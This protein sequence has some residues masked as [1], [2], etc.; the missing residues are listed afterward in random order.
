MNRSLLIGIIA[1]IALFSG[2]AIYFYLNNIKIKNRPAIEAVPG[3]AFIILQSKDINKSWSLLGKSSLWADLKANP[4]VSKLNKQ[5]EE[6]FN[7]INGD[8]EFKE[9]F[10]ENTTAFSLHNNSNNL[11]L[12][13]IV[14]TGKPIELSD[15]T[16]Y[17]SKKINAKAI[18]RSFD[19]TPIYDFTDAQGN[20]LFTISYRD[21]LLL[22][23][24][25]A[26][27]VEESI[28]KLKYNLPNPTKGLTQAYLMAETSA[29]LN[30][31]INYQ[32]IHLLGNLFTKSEYYNI[33]SY[34]K[35]FA[36]W[37]M[38]DVELNDDMYKLSGVTFTDDSVFQFLDLFK[39]QT[40]KQLQ[41]HKYMPKNTAMAFQMGFSDYMKF[42]SELNEYLQVNKKGDLYVGFSDSIENRYNIDITQNILNYIDGEAS[43]V[44]T[45]PAGSDF[46]NNLNAF[47]RFKDPAG[48][49]TALKG[50]IQAMNR[51]GEIDSVTY[52]HQGL[53]I[54]RIKLGNFLKLYYGEIM[55]H[56]YSPYYV[57]LDDIFVFANDVNT[58]KHI[59]D[60]YKSGNTL[61]NDEKFKTYQEDLAVNNNVSIFISPTRNFLL[62]TNFVNDSF[63]STLN[64]FQYDFKKFEFF[65]IQ[66]SN[67]NNKAFYTQVS[68][69]YNNINTNETQL[70][71]ASK[72]DTIF[73]IAPQVV[74]N[75]ELK[76]NIIFVQDINNTL[77]CIST[78]GNLIWRS[79]LNGKLVGNFHVIDPQKNGTSCYLFSTEKQ[80]NL[81]DAK[82]VSLYNY[83]IRYPG[84]A[85]LPFTIADFYDDSTL[86][87][88]VALENNRIVGYALNG[89][90]L[91]GWM[92]KV[93][94]SKAN[95]PIGLIKKG[96]KRFIYTTNIKGQLC[97]FDNKGKSVKLSHMNTA[98]LFEYVSNI[99]S[100]TLNFNMFDSTG[101]ITQIT[102]D[103]IYKQIG[104]PKYIGQFEPFIKVVVQ[105]DQVTNNTFFLTQ[106][107]NSWALYGQDLKKIANKTYTDSIPQFNYFTLDAVGKVMLANFQKQQSEYYWYNMKGE[108]YI[109]FPIKGYTPFNTANLM[110]DRGNYLIGG[111]HQ[112]NIFVYKLK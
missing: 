81:I 57:Q 112:N 30:L 15:I 52:Y 1:T 86:Q 67:T 61:A 37:S 41:L 19:K 2:I 43:L 82:G 7:I 16:D 28:R 44:M 80:A 42:N 98:N 110:M 59:I 54:E 49:S 71:W 50:I 99:D 69:K 101:L 75:S 100:L 58:L 102:F 94:E 78:N 40:P 91:Q 64:T 32:K 93:I 31:F 39:N 84:K 68:Y 36:N 90:P 53:E 47:I 79:K 29:D 18:L 108:L 10:E 74:Y 23:A 45:E 4:S 26:S 109:D 14:E 70:L 65:S 13:A 89:K 77:Y 97:I 17:L 25:D 48:M 11:G 96:L 21:Q 73:D 72:L 83:P 22:C 106:T 60:Q 62:P 56:I 8:E 104:E 88:F 111:D 103:S 34:I 38:L 35:G 107:Q 9:I 95:A 24:A 66:F 46:H 20:T 27:L 51:K 5:L 55:E 12:L 63:F 6:T 85:L 105:N 33:L 92:P 76:Q 87:F 3:D